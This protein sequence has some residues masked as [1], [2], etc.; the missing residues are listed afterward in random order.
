MANVVIYTTATC[1]YCI[2]AKRLL[3]KK[4]TVFEEIKVDG[5]PAGRAKMS[6]LAGGR[7]SVPQIFI[8]G[9]HIGGCDDLYDLEREGRLDQLLSASETKL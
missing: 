2:A 7:T 5:D 1:P 4:S 6:A 3:T 9:R 8:G